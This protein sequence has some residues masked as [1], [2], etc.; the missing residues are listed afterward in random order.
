MRADAL[1][2]CSTYS[3]ASGQHLSQLARRYMNITAATIA[4]RQVS[5][6]TTNT[7]LLQSE[8]TALSRRSAAACPNRTLLGHCLSPCRA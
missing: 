6:Q 2:T 4:Q 5:R 1:G 3:S 7:L 8:Q